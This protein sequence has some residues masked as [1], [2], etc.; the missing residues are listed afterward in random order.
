M[1]RGAD[2]RHSRGHSGICSQVS[3]RGPLYPL[4]FRM[5]YAW[6]PR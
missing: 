4:V 3:T 2:Q 6:K 5:K 1:H